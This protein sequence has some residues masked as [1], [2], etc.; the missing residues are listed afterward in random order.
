VS[1]Q[2]VRGI[3]TFPSVERIRW[4]DLPEVYRRR[5]HEILGVTLVGPPPIGV[6]HLEWGSGLQVLYGVNGAGKT[7]ILNGL[8]A[9]LS[10]RA[11]EGG[12]GFLH[13]RILDPNEQFDLD[14]D[15]LPAALVNAITSEVRVQ[16]MDPE[17]AVHFRWQDG[18]DRFG[19]FEELLCSGT[20]A[21]EVLQAL[22][23][24]AESRDPEFGPTGVEVAPQGR[25]SLLASGTAAPSY[26]IFAAGRVAE[27]TPA[28]DRQVTALR[29]YLD[30]RTKGAPSSGNDQWRREESRPF[31]NSD[32]PAWV[33]VPLVDLG[34]LERELVS[35]F[36]GDLGDAD[37]QTHEMLLRW[38]RKISELAGKVVSEGVLVPGLFG[39]SFSGGVPTLDAVASMMS[40]R[41]TAIL[42]ELLASP[43]AL[44]LELLEQVRWVEGRFAAWEALD[45]LSLK[46]VPLNRLSRA[47]ARWASFAI[48]MAVADTGPDPIVVQ[49]DQVP[50]WLPA[51]HAVAVIDEPEAAL[52]ERAI[53]FL[54]DGLTS[55]AARGSTPAFVATH[56]PAFLDHRRC[57]VVNVDRSEGLA[58]ARPLPTSITEPLDEMCA[59]LGL[60]RSDLL[61]LTSAYLL[62]EG[63]RDT[64]VLTEL[65][66]QRLN[67]LRTRIVPMRG[68]HSLSSV[69]D[70]QFVFD[71]TT[72]AVVV[73]LDRVRADWLDGVWTDAYSALLDD[74]G[75]PRPGLNIIDQ[76]LR[77]EGS[78]PEE[79]SAL[80]FAR[81][82]LQRRLEHRV[83]FFGFERPDIIYYLKAASFVPGAGSWDP[84]QAEYLQK[85]SGGEKFYDWLRTVHSART[86]V[87][88]FDK[89]ARDLDEVPAEFTQLLAVVE[90]ATSG[91]PRPPRAAASP[92]P[93]Q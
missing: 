40:E 36:V 16:L 68:T 56:S 74:R 15:Y 13:I 14:Y 24:M 65:I 62:V 48:Q 9:V 57:H 32:R 75:R 10:G 38:S 53:D 69:I 92:L 66:G 27:D 26:R 22:A 78:S 23:L 80:E 34:V 21:E 90:E 18:N 28:L 43:P 54:L 47:Q 52:H 59:Q 63:E 89:A 85:R 82:A 35:V 1:E 93:E 5:H 6:V 41:A 64:V 3:A 70:S 87:Q 20:L 39:I 33:P 46:L 11:V 12:Q 2:A 60:R 81:Q 37:R 71:Y 29:E 4:E 91:P 86:S 67:E 72:S 30:E 17:G 25:F 44:T 19:A 45:P 49:E 61:Q 84:L 42:D 55:L 79:R 58:R 8:T 31:L 51:F 73:C 88:A 50:P 7:A 83:R 76:A 77:E